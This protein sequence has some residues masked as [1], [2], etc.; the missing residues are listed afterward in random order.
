M[1]SVSRPPCSAV[2]T[3]FLALHDSSKA[4][5]GV[6]RELRTA[7]LL[8]ATTL[9]EFEIAKVVNKGKKNVQRRLALSKHV[10]DF[11]RHTN[12]TLPTSVHPGLYEWVGWN[13]QN[14][15]WGPVT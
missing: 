10:Q 3:D 9:L 2:R 7:V 12:Q 8:G 5:T 4:N 11:Q 1:F 6:A 14:L 13:E 15:G